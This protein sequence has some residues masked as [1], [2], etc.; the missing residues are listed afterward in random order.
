MTDKIESTKR[1]WKKEVNQL[2]DELDC[3]NEKLLQLD[4]T[5]SA[6]EMYK[7][8]TEDMHTLRKRVAELEALNLEGRISIGSD[9]HKGCLC[10]S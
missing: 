1:N 2:K 7:K 5:Q 3:C 4:K 8:R 9:D 10:G 6:L